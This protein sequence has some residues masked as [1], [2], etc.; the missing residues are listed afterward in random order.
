[1]PRHR[2][3]RRER[4]NRIYSRLHSSSL[5]GKG[6]TAK[7]IARYERLSLTRTFNYLRILRGAKAPIQ[8][9]DGRFYYVPPR[10]EA[11]RPQQRSVKKDQIEFR[12]YLNYASS[13][14]RS[15]DIYIDCIIVTDRDS[16]AIAAAKSRIESLVRSKFG[17]SVAA[18]L[19]FGLSEVS[20]DSA[21]HF[22]YRR[23]GDEWHEL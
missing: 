3:A 2:F 22:L 14:H 1:M 9:L 5:Q 6:L 11:A 4:T 8:K 16:F 10:E 17:R 13:G 20:A 18:M 15:R 7:Q 12:G 21:D 19:H 23:R